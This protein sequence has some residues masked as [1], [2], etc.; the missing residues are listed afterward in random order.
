VIW[1]SQCSMAEK[2]CTINATD[3]QMLF[4]DDPVAA[5]ARLVELRYG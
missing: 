2:D 1:M 4:L 3:L 5:L